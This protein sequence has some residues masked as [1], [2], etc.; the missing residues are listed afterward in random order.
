MKRRPNKVNNSER[1][2]AIAALHER[3]K[4]LEH[5]FDSLVQYMRTYMDW[6]GDLAPF[7]E[8][9]ERK[10]DEKRDMAKEKQEADSEMDRA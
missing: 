2:M 10:F 7:T 9:Q 8:E 4:G 6:K 1:D 5:I 3:V